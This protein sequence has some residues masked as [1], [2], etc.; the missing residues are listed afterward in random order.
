[1]LN[2]RKSLSAA[3]VA[4]ALCSSPALAGNGR[5]QLKALPKDAAGV[6]VVNVEQLAKSPLFQDLFKMATANPQAQAGLA[7][8]GKMIGMDPLTAVKTLAVALPKGFAGQGLVLLQT[9][10]DPK[11]IEAAAT[12]AGMSSKETFNG[13]TLLK[14]G[15]GS[16]LG[17]LGGQIFLGS[18]EQVKGGV[19]AAKGKGA[20]VEKNADLMKLVNAAPQTQD[21]WFAARID[22]APP[23]ELAHAKALRGGVD[24]EKGV[25]VQLVVTMESDAEA[26]KLAEESK[27]Q[28]DKAKNE[29]QAKMLGLDAIAGKVTFAAKAKDV[30]IKI[31]LDEADVG[32]LKSTIGMMMMMANGAAAGGMQGGGMPGGGMPMQMPAPPVQR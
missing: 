2:L 18:N 32:R 19:G 1:M 21:A 17:M 6:L 23:G 30:E 22:N 31:P 7:E 20:S 13:A 11:K 14:A 5:D 25:T 29:P 3:A 8:F 27:V 16:T 9:S 4:V 12:Q 15:D 26:K 24:L 10:A 28:L